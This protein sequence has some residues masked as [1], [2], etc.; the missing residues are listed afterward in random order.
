MYT[1]RKIRIKENDSLY[2]YCMDIC[3]RTKRL[4]NTANFY[5]RQ[6]MS[7]LKKPHKERQPAENDG[8]RKVMCGIERLNRL[9]QHS[10]EKKMDAVRNDGKLSDDEKASMIAGLDRPTVVPF[11]SEK[12]WF[13]GYNTL[14]G[15]LKT[16]NDRNYSSL[17]A[18]TAQQVVKQVTGDWNSYFKSLEAYRKKPELFTGRPGIV[19][20]KKKGSLSSAVFTY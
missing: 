13:L 10:F 14:E 8:I 3:G 12:K 1:V 18:Q 5:I 20:Y 2:G 4:Y 15:I 6:N 7:G 19:K 16:L 17:P 11:P 9:R